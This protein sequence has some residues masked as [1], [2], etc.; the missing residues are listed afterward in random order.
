MPK[1]NAIFI[2]MATADMQFQ[3]N[4][5]PTEDSKVPALDFMI[6]GGGMA[7]NA[8]IAFSALGG[9]AVLFAAVGEGG[10]SDIVRNDLREHDVELVDMAKGEG[11]I[12]ISSIVSSIQNA[13]RTIVMSSF[14]NELAPRRDEMAQKLCDSDVILIDGTH[15]QLLYEL[16]HDARQKG[17]QVIMDAE[18]WNEHT[19]SILRNV[20][21]AICSYN[22]SP[23]SCSGPHDIF[24]YLASTGV[25]RSAITSGSRHIEFYEHGIRGTIPVPIID[26]I[27]TLGAG[28][29]L[30]GAF[31]FFYSK[32]LS[33]TDALRKSSIIAS[34][35]CKTF[36]TREWTKNIRALK[37]T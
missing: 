16:L 29:F 7:L 35:S 24:Q 3:L 11:R 32:G 5:Y 15:C 33:F 13:S 21:V 2:G 28:D 25:H 23:P 26:A 34:E 37:L 17:T 6:N 12:P 4:K 14:T 8:S 18:I 1:V 10:L 30:H 22:F 9:K 20:D 31:C 36:G 19:D 27:D